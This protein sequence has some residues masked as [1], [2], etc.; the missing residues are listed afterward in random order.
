MKPGIVRQQENTG[1]RIRL[2][3]K[4]IKCGLQICISFSLSGSDST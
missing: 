4:L 2:E 3:I 1:S